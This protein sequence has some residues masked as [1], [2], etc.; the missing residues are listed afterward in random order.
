MRR[1]AI[2]YR[3]LLLSGGFLFI[4][5]VASPLEAYV[6]PGAGFAFLSSFL[7]LFLTFFL[8]VFSLLSWPFRFFFRLIKGQKAYKKSLIDRMVIVGLDGMEPTLVEK[9]M[10]EG[11]LPN[12]SR[13]KDTGSYARLS[14][15]TPAISPVAWS[16]FM[17]GSHP[18]KHNIF[19]FLSRNPHTYLP[20]L[21]SA[22]IGIPKRFLPFGKYRIPLSKP[23]IKGLRKSVPFWKVLGEAGVFSTILRIPITFPPEKFKGH[24]ISGMCAPDLKGSQGTFSFYTSD[25]K[26]AEVDEGGVIIPVSIEGDRITTYISGPD[27]TLLKQPEEMRLPMTIVL[28]RSHNQ[29]VIEVSKQKIR[30]PEKEF[31]PWIKITFRP[32]LGMK[33]RAICR[34]YISDM[35]D[36]FQMY[37]TPFNIDPE[38]PALPISHPLVYSVYLGKLLGSFTTLGEADDTWALNEGI[39]DEDS[40]IQLAYDNHRESED[41][42]F[43]ALDKVKKGVVACWFQTTDSI[44]HMFFRYLKQDHPALSCGHRAKSD[45]VI[46]DLYVNMDNLVGQ[47]LGKMNKRDSLIIMSD[48][49]FKLFC[50]GFNLN[51]WLYLNGYLSLKDG[52]DSSG[53]WFQDVDWSRTKAYGLGLGGIYINQEGREAQ[54]IVKPGPE[55]LALKSELQEKLSGLIDPD[56]GNTAIRRLYDRDEL[57]AGPYK[58]NCPDFIMGYNE[59]YRV[60]WASVSGKVNSEVFED[61][62]KAWSGDHCIDPEL[63]PGVFFSDLPITSKAPSIVDIAPTTLSLFGVDVPLHMDGVPMV[64]LDALRPSKKRLV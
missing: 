36:E 23:M 44:Q 34:F 57:P 35:N 2:R 55:T 18:A 6:G 37:L 15:T 54:G 38:K 8:A 63:V 47:V 50:R 11:K 24:L 59:G 12:L 48:H 45:R 20:D 64:D 14:T 9:F 52:K 49:G 17:T 4:L 60:S 30:L 41:M 13:L 22:Q 43:N 16:S 33:V 58:D 26:K 27:N 39:L 46:E 21:S 62:T 25:V 31:S 5:G 53:E 1:S 7:V 29:A 28:D 56:T 61:N 19:D 10:A 42:L 3:C 40:F 51:S 32:G